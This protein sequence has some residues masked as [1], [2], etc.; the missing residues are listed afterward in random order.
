MSM[1]LK[2]AK[3]IDGLKAAIAKC[4]GDVILR[5]CDGTETFNMKSVISQY[6]AIGELCKDHGDTYEFF[7]MDK[8]DE[9]QLI[10][11]FHDLHTSQ[12]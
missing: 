8:N 5:S 4:K 12:E 1:F 6:M 11:F 2:D 10:A 7:C 9:S 3:D